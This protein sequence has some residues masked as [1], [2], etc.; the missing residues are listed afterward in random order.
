[1]KN[2][3]LQYARKATSGLVVSVVCSFL[4]RLRLFSLGHYRIGP[5][6]F[7]PRYYS[8]V[9]Y[10]LLSTSHALGQGCVGG[11]ADLRSL[12]IKFHCPCVKLFA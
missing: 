5:P 8:Q 9:I 6:G 4:V 10:G 12:V 11:S 7:K 2:D 1:M 3:I